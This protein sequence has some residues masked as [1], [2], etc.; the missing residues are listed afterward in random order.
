VLRESFAGTGLV[1]VQ[2]GSAGAKA[3]EDAG[4]ARIEPGGPLAVALITGDFDLSGIGTVTHVEGDR[5]YGWGHPFMTLGECQLPLM[6]GYVHTVYP[7]QTV[8]FKMGSPLR[9]VGTIGADVSTC[10][11]GRLGPTPDMLPVRMTVRREPGDART[12]N[13]QVVRQRGLMP[14]LV[15]TALVNSVDMEGD[16]PDEM[17]AEMVARIE[18]EGREPVVVKDT[19][20]GGSYAGGRGASA[21]YQQVAAIVSVLTNNPYEPARIKQIVCETTVRTGRT[22]AEIEAVELDSD[23]YSPGDT[24]KATAIV[25]PWQGPPRRCAVSLKLPADLPEGTYT[26]T[27]CDD[28]SRARMDVRDRPEFSNPLSLD[29]IYGLVRH[30]AAA[31]RTHLAVRVALPAVGVTVGSHSLPDLPPGMVQV[32]GQTR[33]TGAVTVGG[34]VSARRPTDWVLY[35]SDS[36]R[37][38][39]TDNKKANR[40]E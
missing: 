19:F 7:R 4:D 12:F 37:F 27:V 8:S 24:L 26:A 16:L 9:A 5:V 40:A 22:S 28:P 13:V 1:P 34:A 33:R 3:I 21:L 30:Q 14:Q 39:V 38:T 35:G 20:S 31:K 15:F 23:V 17:T 25:R 11:A 6:T 18:I 2:G 29:Q 32:L 10:V 36:V